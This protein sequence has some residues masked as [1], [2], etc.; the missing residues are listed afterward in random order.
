MTKQLIETDGAPNPIG[1]YSQGVVFGS[2]LFVAGQVSRDPVTGRGVGSDIASQTR[3]ALRNL[4]AV[5]EA[6]GASPED[7]LRIGVFLGDMKLFREF[8][9]AYSQAVQLTVQPVRITVGADLGPWL[10][11][12]DGIFSLPPVENG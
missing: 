7:A 12:L 9:A 5:A 11:E 6:G 2:L 10:I 4:F 1:A 8:D 3:Q